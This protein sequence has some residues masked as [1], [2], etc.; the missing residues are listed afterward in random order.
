MT[1]TLAASQ[2]PWL[3]AGAKEGGGGRRVCCFEWK[4]QQGTRGKVRGSQRGEFVMCC[5][6]VNVMNSVRD[7]KE[8]KKYI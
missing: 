7:K 4:Q 1:T 3:K 8:K 6:K 2:R 5:S